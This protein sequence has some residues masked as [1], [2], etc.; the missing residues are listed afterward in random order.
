MRPG[1]PKGFQCL[2]KTPFDTEEAAEE[3]RISLPSVTRPKRVYPC[4]ICRK[5]HMTAV[6]EKQSKAKAR[7]NK[8]R[9]S[10]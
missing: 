3:F 4:D 5:W 8:K 10:W 1:R 2:G 7:K 9:G 6:T